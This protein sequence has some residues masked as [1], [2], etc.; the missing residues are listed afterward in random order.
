MKYNS[1]QYRLLVSMT[2]YLDYTMGQLEELMKSDPKF[3]MIDGG[4]K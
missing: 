3:P 2:Q 4:V 1:A